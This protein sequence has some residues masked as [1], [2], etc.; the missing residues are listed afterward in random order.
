[1]NEHLF[2]RYHVR[3]P[4]GYLND[5]NG[6]VLLDGRLHLYFQ[7]RHTVD[8]DAPVLWGHVTSTDFVHWTYERP[9]IAPHPLGADRDGCW[10][11]N[12]VVDDDGAIRA[13]YSGLVAGEPLQ[14]TLTAVSH[15]GGRSFGD[16]AE[17]VP[18]PSADEGIRQLRDPFVWREDGE[19]QMVVGAAGPDDTAMVR[20]YRSADL[21]TW[22]YCGPLARMPRTVTREWDSGDMWECPQV[23]WLDGRQV[24]LVGAWGQG[25]G[26]MKVLS[27]LPHADAPD[28]APPELHLVD[29]GTNF[30]APSVLPASPHG[31]L[32]WGWSTEGR[33]R[34]WW[35][36]DGWS[37][38]LTL[39]RVLSL[40]SDGTLA[41]TPVP[42]LES[43]RT[44]PDGL[45]VAGSLEVPDPQFEFALEGF[46]DGDRTVVRLAFGTEEHLDVVVEPARG[47]V[48]V[49]RDRASLDPRAD[50]GRVEITGID[51]LG[52]PGQVIRGFVDGSILELFLPGGH[53]ATVRFYPTTPPPWRIETG[54][55][56][57]SSL[58]VWSLRS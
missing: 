33:S 38:M 46:G 57:A 26:V 22:D 52:A 14:H 21:A 41:S 39:P 51:Q 44:Q 37:G 50:R 40:R 29:Q 24:L 55:A 42:G 30:Y 17:A 1:M 25:V 9:A 31:P 43:L 16:P 34:G 32:V 23:V 19:W 54:G 13:F 27:V 47:T 5:P 7:Y 11:G 8:L 6:P 12:T 4:R 58:R 36:E 15:D 10:S 3:P 28:V 56:P 18:A 45:A 35:Q 20:R 49:D 48:I 53:V 2:P